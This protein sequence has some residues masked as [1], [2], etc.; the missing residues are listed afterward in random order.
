VFDAFSDLAKLSPLFTH[1]KRIEK[2]SDDTYRWVFE[3]GPVKTSYV[4]RVTRETPDQISWQSLPGEP[5]VVHGDIFF[6]GAPGGLGTEVHMRINY[7][8]TQV[9][10]L[11]VLLRLLRQVGQI[12]LSTDLHRVRQY[13]E[14]G[15]LAT[16]VIRREDRAKEDGEY[17]ES[18]RAQLP[19]QG[20]QAAVAQ[21][22]SSSTSFQ[23]PSSSGSA[24]PAQPAS[25]TPAQ[26][27]S[28]TP[29]Q[30]ASATPAQRGASG[31]S[32][33]NGGDEESPAG[34]LFVKS[35]TEVRS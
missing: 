34:T 35:E 31:P 18:A 5:F 4:A 15:E 6:D 25:A 20:R 11:V 2:Q 23:T 32:A 1:V 12:Q 27:A 29:A 26:P 14:T 28:A 19:S 8:P 13:L 22:L 7:A 30:P 33:Q 16:N 10:P 17:M 9:R 21:G 24:T 3:R